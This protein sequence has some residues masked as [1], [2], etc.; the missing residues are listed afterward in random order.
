LT[1]KLFKT[2]E[3]CCHLKYTKVLHTMTLK[4]IYCVVTTMSCY[5]TDVFR[6]VKVTSDRVTIVDNKTELTGLVINDGPICSTYYLVHHIILLVWI[7]INL[8]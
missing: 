5:F 4:I 1:Q 7:I 2:N 3:L 6:Y 8:R